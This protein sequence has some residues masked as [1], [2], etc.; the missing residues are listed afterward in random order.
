MWG[1]L[2][3][4]A[5]CRAGLSKPACGHPAVRRGWAEGAQAGPLEGREGA[6]VRK[7]FPGM[8]RVRRWPLCG[9]K[10]SLSR[11]L[12]GDASGRVRQVETWVGMLCR[13]GDPRSRALRW[14]R[15][16]QARLRRSRARSRRPAPATWR[17]RATFSH[18]SQPSLDPE[19]SW[20]KRPVH[21]HVFLHCIE[22]CIFTRLLAVRTWMTNRAVGLPPTSPPVFPPAHSSA[23][24]RE[25]L[26]CAWPHPG[27]E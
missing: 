1:P 11:G 14:E 9:G 12:G 7:E 22:F 4:C 2:C 19:N 18:F 10:S 20:F 26:F 17:H 6:S 13:R 3:F 5:A 25:H 23:A 24:R 15:G 8:G 27:P 21:A 16:W